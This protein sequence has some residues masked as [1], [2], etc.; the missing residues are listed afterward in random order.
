MI[1]L[2][3]GPMGVIILQ[4]INVSNQHVSYL[5]LMQCSISIISSSSNKVIAILPVFLLRKE[6][7]FFYG[8]KKGKDK[9]S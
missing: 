4:Y 3:A 5:K 9:R 2:L 8:T 7:I 1:E 6:F